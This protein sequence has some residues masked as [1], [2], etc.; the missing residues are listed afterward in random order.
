MEPLTQMPGEEDIGQK[1]AA[2][3][4]M[5]QNAENQLTKMEPSTGAVSLSDPEISAKSTVALQ[6]V[7]PVG[8]PLANTWMTPATPQRS[9]LKQPG[10][11]VRQASLTGER[12]VTPPASNNRR[13]RAISG[14][15]LHEV[16]DVWS[17][18]ANARL[19]WQ[20]DREYAVRRSFSLEGTFE[21]VAAGLLEQYSEEQ[22]RPVA[23]I[24]RDPDNNQKVLVVETY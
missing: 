4:H 24:Y 10:V 14:S 20:A 8:R 17:S 15:N 19:V 18:N 1:I 6:D 12:T 16:L 21:Q 9:G 3:E 7:Q 11:M 5:L 2:L 13:W 22:V 23:R